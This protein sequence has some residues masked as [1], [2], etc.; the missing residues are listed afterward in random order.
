MSFVYTD[1][2]MQGMR[3]YGLV[4]DL[5]TALSTYVSAVSPVTWGYYKAHCRVSYGSPSHQE[6]E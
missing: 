5:G 2:L 4:S 6:V 3:A 1:T